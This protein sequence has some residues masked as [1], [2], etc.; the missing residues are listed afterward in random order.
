MID[1][2]E[3][4]HVAAP[5]ANGSTPSPVGHDTPS[6]EAL[7]FA[8]GAITADQLGELVRDA[9]LTQ[10]PAAALAVERG[11]ATKS[12]LDALLTGSNAST[13]AA[14]ALGEAHVPA[15][16]EPTVLEPTQSAPVVSD[17]AQGAPTIRLSDVANG[18]L[19][20]PAATFAEPSPALAPQ[21]EAVAA[22][23][24]VVPTYVE[25][26][27][28]AA[29]LA[30]QPLPAEPHSAAVQLERTLP[31]GSPA[32]AVSM[33]LRSGEQ[34]AVD[35]ADTFEAATER[36]RAVARTV[37]NGDEWPFVSGRLIRPEAVV[38]IDIERA[39]EA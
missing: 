7:L 15:P 33:R 34:V 9:V 26:T 11:F 39:L 18:V 32:F 1:S 14:D 13:P 10:R 5:G 21:I 25:E 19:P 36:A 20:V 12:T 24:R 22:S 35:V 29:A 28:R 38:S 30:A 31:G 16:V 17:P 4:E 3:T 6:V 37:A 8:A 2:F 23:P 27:V